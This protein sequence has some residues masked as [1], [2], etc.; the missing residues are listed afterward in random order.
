MSVRFRKTV[1][2]GKGARVTFSKSG[3]SFSLGPRGA[4]IS[5]GKRGT[6]VNLGIPGTGLS[7][8]M[9]IAGSSKSKKAHSRS[10]TG[11][12]AT[13]PSPERVKTISE[14][15][16]HMASDGSLALKASI[17]DTGKITFE[18]TDTGETI[19]DKAIIREIK[20]YP[21]MQALIEKLQRQ[22]QREWDD[23][24]RGMEDTNREFIDIFMLTPEVI[25]SRNYVDR[26]A[27]LKP[28]KYRRKS[29]GESMPSQTDIEL[30][31][32][33]KAEREIKSIFGKKKK[34]DEYVAANLSAFSAERISDWKKRRAA[35]EANE[36]ERELAFNA[37]LMAKYQD[38]KKSLQRALES[39]ADT[40]LDEVE[41]CIFNISVSADVSAQVDYGNGRVFLDLDLP[42]IED[43]PRQTT[44]QLK[45]GQVKIVDKPQKQLKQEYAIC[46][47]GLAFFMAA[48]I[49]NVNANIQE[50]LV[51]GY[52]QRRDKNGDVTDQYIYSILFPRKQ[53]VGKK[54]DNPLEDVNDFQNRMKLSTAFNFGT[55]RPYDLSELQK[56]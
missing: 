19:T 16:R 35:F 51:S 43:L 11:S 3:P 36:D 50:V 44:K 12:R 4:S 26:L 9:K 54:I 30:V 2:P 5:H 18:F 45:S 31:L 53:L 37:K 10:R 21:E 52:T 33:E 14:L 32:R 56:A 55:I 48:N 27:S 38:E 46:V 1:S 8:N 24:Q 22:K 17:D 7:T 25:P 49:F 15:K 6:Y 40:V 29:F 28:T 42:E 39:D 13:S 41:N 20:K 23:L 34:I 47:L